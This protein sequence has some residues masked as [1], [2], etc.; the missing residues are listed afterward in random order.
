LLLQAFL[1]RLVNGGGRI[2]R[3]YGLGRGRVDL[4]IV[5]K[6]RDQTQRV[7]IEIKMRRGS[8]EAVIDKGL[9]QTKQ[10]MDRCG[11]TAGHLAIFDPDVTRSW[12]ERIFRHQRDGIT[13]WG[14]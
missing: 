3:E 2:E 14:M 4:L 13:V 1:Q 8:L 9:A 5:W 11:T 7:V 6:A 10:Y 12:D